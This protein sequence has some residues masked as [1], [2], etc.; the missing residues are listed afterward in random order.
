M[1]NVIRFSLVVMIIFVSLFIF[2]KQ[3]KK[4][5]KLRQVETSK[6]EVQR[7]EPL[8]VKASDFQL[9]DIKGEPIKLSSYEGKQPVILFFW[10]SGCDLCKVD[11]LKLNRLYPLIKS[12]G[13]ELLSINVGESKA[14]IE[15]FLRYYPA[16]FT[17]L[18][19]TN[20]RVAYAYNLMGVPTYVLINKEGYVIFYDNYFP[21]E[22]YFSLLKSN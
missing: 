4:I 11:I 6:V 13:I 1:R 2:L 10:Y 19:D 22:N 18:Q 8:R 12:L 16:E 14:K 9:Y 21:E 20:T 17:V 3:L 5:V 7:A 15:R